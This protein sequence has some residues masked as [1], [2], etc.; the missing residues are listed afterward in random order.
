MRHA[1][2]RGATSTIGFVEVVRN[3]DRVGSFPNLLAQLLG[4]YDEIVVTP[5]VRDRAAALPGPIKAMDA[6]HLASAE[7]LGA[8]LVSFISYDIQLLRMARSR[9][10]PAAAPGLKL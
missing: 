9:G 1:Q 3:C 10:L 2:Y 5:S 6:I 4:D 8:E 7:Q